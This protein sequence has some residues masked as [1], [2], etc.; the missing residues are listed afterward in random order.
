M[1]VDSEARHFPDRNIE[2]HPFTK[3]PVMRRGEHYLEL[4]YTKCHDLLNRLEE[5]LED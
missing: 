3:L 1:P 2:T 4:T 5:T